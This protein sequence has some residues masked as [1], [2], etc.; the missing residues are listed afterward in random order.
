MRLWYLP[1]S[2]GLLAIFSGNLTFL[3]A[4][5]EGFIETCFP[6]FEGCSSISKAGR[7]GLAAIF[8]KLTIIPV[9][10]LLSVYWVITYNLIRNTYGINKIQGKIML[11][12]G[13]IG[14]FFGIIYTSFLGSE[15]DIY[16]LLRRFGIYFFF[17]GTY[18]GQ[19]LETN[20][21][22]NIEATK[23]SFY[24]KTMR[25]I[26]FFI[27]CIILI[28]MPVY[29]FFDEDDWLENI[30]EWNITLLIFLYFIL[31]SL[32]WRIGKL[33]LNLE[34]IYLERGKP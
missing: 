1:L 3:L 4:V 23:L 22:G 13:I 8:F 12:F 11:F 28:S 5:N 14:S 9:M 30:L 19:I 15:G 21:I 31:S 10:T 33:R 7:K 24:P 27:G 26:T 16:Q 18:L 25:F 6:Y 34:S 2:I 17:L 32:F 29:G 20:L